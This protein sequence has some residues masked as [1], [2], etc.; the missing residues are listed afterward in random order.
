[1]AQAILSSLATTRSLPVEIN[2]AGLLPGGEPM[3]T[4]TRDALAALG[5]PTPGF[6]SRSSRQLTLPTVQLADLVLGMAR[7][8]VREIVVRA[9]EAWPRTFTLK[10]LVRRGKAVGPRVNDEQ[11][12]SWLTRVSLHRTRQGLLGSS[13]L[14]DVADPLGGLPSAF[15]QTADEICALCISLGELLWP[16]APT[17][18][19]GSAW[20]AG[21]PVPHTG[22]SR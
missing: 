21:S 7:E 6:A 13:E 2:S 8:H 22:Q 20:G 18:T 1:M 11:L 14:D 3:P 10:E 9:P 16:S 17:R 15:G 19:G 5:Y 12:E 4:E